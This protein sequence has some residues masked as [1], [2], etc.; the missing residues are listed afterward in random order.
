METHLNHKFTALLICFILINASY[1]SSSSNTE[2]WSPLVTD[3]R[4]NPKLCKY[5]TGV[6]NVCARKTTVE[7]I[8]NL[9]DAWKAAKSKNDSVAIAF[10]SEKKEETGGN[11]QILS[12]KLSY[13]D[14][15]E[16]KSV[17]SPLID[18][19]ELTGINRSKSQVR[20]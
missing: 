7:Q 6:Q 18:A 11:G 8:K 2:A 1:S 16:F 12:T 10:S 9:E 19:E 17:M 5:P 15:F 20:T 13:V 14:P 4:I 3:R